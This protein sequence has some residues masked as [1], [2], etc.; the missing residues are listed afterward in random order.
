MLLVLPDA[1]QTYLGMIMMLL[2][3]KL[4]CMHHL[5]RVDQM[6]LLVSV[7]VLAHM[8]CDSLKIG[9]IASKASVGLHVSRC[10]I[11]PI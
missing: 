4:N 2:S 6:H 5:I 8:L 3:F 11:D 9:S 1:F 10:G 7:M